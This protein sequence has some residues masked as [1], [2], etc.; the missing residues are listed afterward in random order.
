MTVIS[1]IRNAEFGHN[2]KMTIVSLAFEIRGSPR[3]KVRGSQRLDQGQFLTI[4]RTLKP[5]L[6]PAGIILSQCR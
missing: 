2:F 5:K 6:T 3:T 4:K 1:L